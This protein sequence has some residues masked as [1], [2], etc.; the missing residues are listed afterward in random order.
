MGS[1]VHS[2]T[3][4]CGSNAYH[5]YSQDHCNDVTIWTD[6]THYWLFGRRMI[7][8]IMGTLMVSW[9][10]AWINFWT[11]SQVTREMNRRNGYLTSPQSTFIN[12]SSDQ[13]N[14]NTKQGS[15]HKSCLRVVWENPLWTNYDLVSSHVVN[16]RHVMCSFHKYW[17]HHFKNE[18][19]VTALNYRFLTPMN[20]TLHVT[21]HCHIIR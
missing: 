12:S 15:R 3:T 14:L 9:L 6:L 1:K 11:N 7:P 21:L 18:V 20:N 10:L 19:P 16:T 8:C 13:N 2:T 4:Q 5:D 17:Q